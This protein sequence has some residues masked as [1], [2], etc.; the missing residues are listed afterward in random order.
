MYRNLLK[1]VITGFW[2]GWGISLTGLAQQPKLAQSGFQFLSVVTDARVAALGGAFTARFGNS[3]SVFYNPATVAFV[4]GFV[5]LSLSRTQW[6]ADINYFSGSFTMNPSG[7][8][9]GQFTVSILSVDY[10]TI[11]GTILDPTT[12][13]GFQDT[14]LLHPYAYAV[15]IGY[16]KMFTPR[17]AFGA[18]IKYVSQ[19]LGNAYIPNPGGGEPLSKQYQAGVV[20]VD[21]GT[22][23]KVG[24]KSL[25][26]GMSV[27]NFAQE[28][29]YESEGFQL[30]MVFNIG[31]AM[32]VLDVFA[33]ENERHA[34]I[35][36]FD[37]NHP[38]AALEQ[39]KFGAEYHFLKVLA[40]RVG[41]H[42]NVDER[43]FSFGVGIQK[44]LGRK[45]GKIAIDYAY[46]PFGIFNAVQHF[47]V[48]FA[49]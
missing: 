29:K 4:P 30:P 6:I 47:T 35:L 24:I 48:R 11:Q 37:A 10:G 19:Y 36:S 2:L 33:P 21:F 45:G 41:Y 9:W 38:R 39:I 22:I 32:N 5:D 23:Y 14:E 13:Q 49:M 43:N 27:Q 46:T 8:R 1:L 20:A 17:F 34:L 7:G 26:F 25:V 18:H 12:E 44:S 31:V 42:A 15:G 28:I 16:A 3:A 40:L